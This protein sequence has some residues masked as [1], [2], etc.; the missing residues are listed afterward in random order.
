S[1]GGH[2]MVYGS[3]STP[4]TGVGNCNNGA[5]NALTQTGQADV[6]DGLIQLPQGLTFPTPAAPNPAPPTTATA[7]SGQTCAGL[8]LSAPQCTGSSGN[9][10]FDAGGGTMVF[11][12]VTL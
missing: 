8:G 1:V 10:T 7:W 2:A 11:G 12:D 9:L 4:R 6:S 5:I 3:L